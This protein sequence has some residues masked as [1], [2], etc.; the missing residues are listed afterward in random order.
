MKKSPPNLLQERLEIQAVRWKV[1]TGVDLVLA[2]QY[3]HFVRGIH[4]V[5]GRAFDDLR[6]EEIGFG[7]GGDVLL[8][9]AGRKDEDYPARIRSLARYLYLKRRNEGKR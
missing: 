2:Y 8:Q 6:S 3:L 4:L 7:A 9:P 1:A 5:S